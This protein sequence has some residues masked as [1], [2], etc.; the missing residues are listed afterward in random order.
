MVSGV[1]LMCP[2]GVLVPIETGAGI[3]VDANMNIE[4]LI[5]DRN[6]SKIAKKTPEKR[7]HGA[8]GK[9]ISSKLG[10]FSD[11]DQLSFAASDYRLLSMWRLLRRYGLS[12]FAASALY[13]PV[14]RKFVGLYANCSTEPDASPA[15]MMRRL[16]LD[17]ET[18]IRFADLLQQKG[19]GQLFVDEF[20][21]IA[22]RVNYNQEETE[23]SAFAGLVTLVAASG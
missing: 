5:A 18:R 21:S 7:T 19:V 14:L 16:G 6:L 22:T 12:P 1:P 4:R 3:W 15:A 8:T 23:I 9:Y 10:I 17:A 13:N 20:A 2:Q 11:G